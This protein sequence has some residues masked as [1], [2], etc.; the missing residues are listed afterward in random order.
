MLN[1]EDNAHK[2]IVTLMT[3]DSQVFDEVTFSI[4]SENPM[5]DEIL[6]YVVDS[7]F[8]RTNLHPFLV[9]SHTQCTLIYNGEKNEKINGNVTSEEF[10]HGIPSIIPHFTVSIKPFTQTSNYPMINLLHR[11]KDNRDEQEGKVVWIEKMNKQY[12]FCLIKEGKPFLVKINSLEKGFDENVFTEEG[13]ER[14]SF[15]RSNV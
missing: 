13:K 1:V 6:S 4:I 5:K 11:T 12:Y 8:Y 7:H 9:D 3:E 10:F 2:V 14:L 15:L